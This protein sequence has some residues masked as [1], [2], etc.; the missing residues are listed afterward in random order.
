MS[1]PIQALERMLLSQERRDSTRVQES[2]AMMQLA[3]S[4][5]VQQKQL[6]MAEEKQ[7]I[8]IMGSNL[9]LLNKTNDT[10]KL[11]SA[12]NFLQQSGLSAL[13]SEF[14]DEDGGLEK[15]RD[16]LT[17][18]DQGFGWSD[19]E[20]I[21]KQIASDLISATWAAYEQ[22]NPNAIINIGSK[23]HYIDKSDS[24]ADD[25]DKRLF[26]SFQ[27]MGILTEKNRDSMLN[28]FKTMR[29][30]L[31]N[32]INLTKEISEFARGDYKINREFDLINEDLIK[33]DL[34][35]KDPPPPLSNFDTILPP[36]KILQRFENRYEELQFKRN[37]ILESISQLE[38]LEKNASF[39]RKMNM[40]IPE[41][42][43]LALQN[44]DSIYSEYESKLNEVD[45]K[46]KE[47]AEV[48]KTAKRESAIRKIEEMPDVD[49]AP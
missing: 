34:T 17:G 18:K 39:Y 42:D 14:K 23:L 4:S 19:K 15:A 11:R 22:N 36:D 33:L 48:T 27:N 25:Y 44:K 2:L 30:S 47:L 49:I 6:Q 35:K 45:S 12:E 26:K 29:K 37:E 16:K 41:Q 32:E 8:A 38:D 24:Y 20:G 40:D 5:V 31:D 28:Q 9:E 21:D 13:Y 10:M 46:I 1:S 7:N 43:L 3:Q